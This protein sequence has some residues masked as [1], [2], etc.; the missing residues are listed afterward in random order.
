MLGLLLKILVALAALAMGVWMGLPGRYT[1][2]ADDIEEVM[3]SGQGRRRKVKRTF[4]PLAWLQ[5]K[6]SASGSRDRRGFKLESPD[7]R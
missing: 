2:S 5:R 6:A 4:T 1:Q 7:D 3:A